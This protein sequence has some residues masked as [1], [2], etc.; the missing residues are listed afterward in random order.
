[1]TEPTSERDEEHQYAGYGGYYSS[2]EEASKSIREHAKTVSGGTSARADRDTIKVYIGR[3]SKGQPIYREVKKSDLAQ[4]SKEEIKERYGERTAENIEIEK[5]KEGIEV[6][7]AARPET[8]E[9]EGIEKREVQKVLKEKYGETYDNPVFR[10][11]IERKT[12]IANKEFLTK[13]EAVQALKKAGIRARETEEGIEY[14]VEARKEEYRPKTEPEKYES[15]REKQAERGVYLESRGTKIKSVIE[16]ELKERAREVQARQEREL[17][18]SAGE[19][20]LTYGSLYA[21]GIAAK[22]LVE[23]PKVGVLART[24][25]YG[26][27]VKA[28]FEEFKE[29]KKGIKEKRYGETLLSGVEF[30]TGGLAFGKG[31]EAVKPGEAKAFWELLPYRKLKNVAATK[32]EIVK[33]PHYGKYIEELKPEKKSKA[34]EVE[35]LTS[36]GIVRVRRGKIGLSIEEAKFTGEKKGTLLFEKPLPERVLYKEMKL[37]EPFEIAK[38]AKKPKP[39]PRQREVIRG[40][41]LVL[42]EPKRGVDISRSTLAKEGE[43]ILKT[44]TKTKAKKFYPQILESEVKPRVKTRAKPI[45]SVV[46]K[47][48]IVEKGKVI[49]DPLRDLER[50]LRV[51]RI[52]IVKIP[53][54]S[55]QKKMSKQREVVKP[56]TT[57]EIK[58]I[59]ATR[60]INK[61]GEGFEKLG[62]SFVDFFRP[63]T[64]RTKRPKKPKPVK[65]PSLSKKEEPKPYTFR[66]P[67]KSI[68][69]WL[70]LFGRKYKKG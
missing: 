3:T 39:K 52:P 12:G 46:R 68:V 9:R 19:M 66:K 55:G 63:T 15:L 41:T 14:E 51:Q 53:L 20:A 45:I 40:G 59:T 22:A 24:G 61:I 57:T 4:M 67:K 69:D 43:A 44:R 18:K 65:V 33:E 28:T 8:M 48:K 62:V 30:V 7:Y 37:R 64:S 47:P 16:E 60:Q 50:N 1:M 38:K 27:G 11:E 26:L 10:R 35:L 54:R 34:R 25:L 49:E 31:F 5:T 29:V 13:K 17:Y 2:P 32:G 70:Y 58:Q 42:P 21:G 56:L 6:R 36:E 23:I